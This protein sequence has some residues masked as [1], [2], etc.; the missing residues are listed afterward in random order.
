[1]MMRR[2]KNDDRKNCS[3]S[4]SRTG[5]GRRVD[6]QQLLLLLFAAKR[7]TREDTLGY[8]E[9][10]DRQT[11][12]LVDYYYYYCC[13]FDVASFAVSQSSVRR[14]N[15]TE[16]RRVKS[17]PHFSS[18]SLL[19]LCDILC[20]SFLP[21]VVVWN[22]NTHTHRHTSQTNGRLWGRDVNSI[23]LHDLTTATPTLV[24]TASTTT[25]I[26]KR[27]FKRRRRERSKTNRKLINQILYPP[28]RETYHHNHHR[29]RRQQHQ[30]LCE[31]W[32]QQEKQR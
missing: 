13:C 26:T 29:R 15:T 16:H 14:R 6:S 19:T 31:T 8:N 9:E 27:L 17:G 10:R 7:D 5:V 12:R 22:Y 23:T 21:L 30:P 4:E 24:I 28:A 32:K 1:M 3:T 2:E 18:L 20:R 11:D 25:I